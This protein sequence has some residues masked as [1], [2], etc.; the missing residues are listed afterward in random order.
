MLDFLEFYYQERFSSKRIF[1]K[2][3]YELYIL[4][5]KF[6]SLCGKKREYLNKNYY[7]CYKNQSIFWIKK[8]G[9]IWFNENLKNNSIAFIINCV[10]ELIEHK[11]NEGEIVFVSGSFEACLDPIAQHFSVKHILSTSMEKAGDRYTGAILPPQTIGDGKAEAI[12]NFLKKYG[13]TDYKK[14]Y[15]YG[16][17]CSDIPMLSLVG[18]PRVIGG[19]HSMEKHAALY[20]WKIVNSI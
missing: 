6:L 1:G 11:K 10:D 20:G 18:N 13:F 12:Q 4:K 3:M 5:S 15:A 14:C 17:H 8:I 16:D 19:D 9:E 2:I 7:R